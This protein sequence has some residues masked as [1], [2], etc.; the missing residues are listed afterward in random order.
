MELSA[1]FRCA[2]GLVRISSC[3]QWAASA[4]GRTVRVLDATTMGSVTAHGVQLAGSCVSLSFGHV[5]GRVAVAAA[6]AE[7]RVAVIDAE[8]GECVADV[9]A[10][11]VGVV[12]VALSDCGALVVVSGGGVGALLVDVNTDPDA[13]AETG[14]NA[15]TNA[16][17]PRATAFVRDVSSHTAVRWLAS[18]NGRFA[19]L[20]GA[21]K[22]WLIV[23]VFAGSVVA[24]SGTE[25]KT[26]SKTKQG[27]VSGLLVG[28]HGVV[29]WGSALRTD[30]ELLYSLDGHLIGTG[31]TLRLCCP[32]PET[33]TKSC[34]LGVR[35]WSADNVRGG[36]LALGGYDGVVRII[37]MDRWVVLSAVVPGE[38]TSEEGADVAVYRE[39]PRVGRAA[40][41]MLHTIGAVDV[42][43]GDGAGGVTHLALRNGWLGAVDE[44]ARNVVC[45]YEHHADNPTVTTLRG[46]LVLRS[47]V[48]SIAWI[49]MQG[50][51]AGALIAV[52]GGCQAYV[53]RKQ[54]AAAVAVER[55]GTPH[56]LSRIV[57]AGVNANPDATRLLLVDPGAGRGVTLYVD[58]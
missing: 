15:G 2:R 48:S 45:I 12:R 43:R 27:L 3:G 20:A 16:K 18:G 9:F 23:D 46:A 42:T 50:D 1:E 47:A 58:E 19:L 24:R 29:T 11:A 14:A 25:R 39:Q 22:G 32:I 17:T 55:R 28:E 54:G 21:D 7:G 26:K 56:A 57:G 4:E 40:S 49:G 31:K 34:K 10:G 36:L 13:D 53:W 30:S 8:T 52:S 6:C 35:V 44:R 5:S 51:P 37:Q 33:K 38:P 41:K